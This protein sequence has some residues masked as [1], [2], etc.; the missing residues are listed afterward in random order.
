MTQT[1]A[2]IEN[3]LWLPTWSYPLHP[4][5]GP[6]TRAV[7][8]TSEQPCRRCE[9]TRIVISSRRYILFKVFGE[10]PAWHAVVVDFALV[11]RYRR[12]REPQ[13]WLTGIK[14]ARAIS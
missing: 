10:I 8:E 5:R 12:M 9:H 3:A 1:A 13:A 11:T 2:Q 4:G 7:Q 6:T 14:D